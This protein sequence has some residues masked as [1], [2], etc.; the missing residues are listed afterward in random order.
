MTTFVAVMLAILVANV[1]WTAVVFGVIC[2]KKVQL[3][4]I[5]YYANWA[6]WYVGKLE[7]KFEKEG[8]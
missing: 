5:E 8:L 3:K 4:L 2:S 1:I 7:E 6:E